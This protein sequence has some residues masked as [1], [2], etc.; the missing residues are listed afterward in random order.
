MTPV[1]AGHHATAP[2][3]RLEAVR[4]NSAAVAKGIA[5][6]PQILAAYTVEHSVNTIT[7]KAMNLLHEVRTL[8]V[9]GYA[10]HLPDNGNALRGARSIHLD[11]GKLGQ[12]QHRGA[13]ATGGPVDQHTLSRP[14]LRR[15]MEHLIGGDVVQ[16]QSY[17]L[18]RV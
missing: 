3:F 18:R 1:A 8:V 15:V 14:G 2:H 7:R 17:R 6:S 9:D 13:H 10:A 16:H 12:L 4:H 11:A 5:G